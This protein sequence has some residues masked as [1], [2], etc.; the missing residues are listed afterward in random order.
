[1]KLGEMLV[2]DGRITNAQL[3]SAMEHQAKDGGRLGSI[4]VELGMIDAETLTVYLGI[5]LGMPIATGAT[6]ERC[7]R[8]AVRLLTPLQAAR[9]RCVPIVIQGQT[10]IV[11]IDDPHDMQ[12]LD[13]LHELTGYRVLPRVAPEIRIHYY[14]ER[15][16]GIPRPAR[17]RKM[18]DQARG[19]PDA[20]S[21]GGGLPGPPLPG[22]P[23][24]RDAVAAPTPAPPLVRAA[25]PVD[26][27]DEHEA[28]ELDAN[29]LVVELEADDAETASQAPPV[30]RAATA[31]TTLSP[32]TEHPIEAIDFATALDTIKTTQ[33]R[34]AVADALLSFAASHFDVAVLC[35]VR[36][37]MAFGW[38]GFGAGLDSSRIETLLVPLDVPSMFQGTAASKEVSRCRVV[39]GT[40]HDHLFK[41][42]RCTPPAGSV[43]A[44]ISIGHRMVNVLYGH[45]SGTA[46][47][48]DDVLEELRELTQAATDAY[49][50]LISASKEKR[51]ATTGEV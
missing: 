36:D 48:S 12:T 1:M 18:G 43:L 24:R 38:K 45:K 3:D 25:E 51:R 32:P 26:D 29:D 15:F 27:D 8:S 40:I 30:E 34:G 17:F 6:L 37:N 14:L 9:H 11:A 35:L 42:L 10:V 21:H 41:I 16:Y 44:P 33:H 31:R 50:R 46:E 7:K 23:P 39:P 13:A 2:R 5:E 19:N 49:L 4:F 28:L 47:I 22:L 20:G